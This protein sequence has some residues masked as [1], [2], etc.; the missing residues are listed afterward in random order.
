MPGM[1]RPLVL[2]PVM[3]IRQLLS[4]LLYA[5]EWKVSHFCKQQLDRRV[6]C[7]L[8]WVWLLDFVVCLNLQEQQPLAPLF[9][10]WL[11]NLP[12]VVTDML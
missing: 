1:I 5:F 9:W 6:Q 7:S 3:G 10:C 11:N 2:Q 4:F 8:S 12:H